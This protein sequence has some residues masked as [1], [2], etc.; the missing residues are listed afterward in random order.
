MSFGIK[1]FSFYH[2]VVSDWVAR[3]PGLFWAEYS[4][5]IRKHS[6]QDI[7][8]KSK[9][10]I[11]FHPLGKSKKVLGG[12]GT[13]HLPPNDEGK[14]LISITSSCNASVGIPLLIYPEFM[15]F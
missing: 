2:F 11:V 6:E 5:E 13:I 4:G 8:I 1:K 12:I 15:I 9:D 7:A 3:V 10:W 14:R